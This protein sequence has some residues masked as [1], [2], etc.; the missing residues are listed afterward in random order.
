MNNQN[1]FQEQFLKKLKDFGLNPMEWSLGG[2]SETQ[3]VLVFKNKL[4]K[5]F[6][7][8]GFFEGEF[9]SAQ[10]KNLELFSI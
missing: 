5:T 9:K 4:D 1:N 2:V 6:Q 10:L 3:K 8:L 7:L